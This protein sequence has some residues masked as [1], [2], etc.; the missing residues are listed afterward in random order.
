MA[1]TKSKKGWQTYV[2]LVC[3]ADAQEKLKNIEEQIKKLEQDQHELSEAIQLKKLNAEIGRVMNRWV[4]V[5]NYHWIDEK[6]EQ[7]EGYR[8]FKVV[9]VN[10]W[11]GRNAFKM[12]VRNVVYIGKHDVD[13][14]PNSDEYHVD[15]LHNWKVVSE[16]TV[17]KAIKNAREK[18][19]KKFDSI[20]VKCV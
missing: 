8:Y 17:E 14:I 12:C 20:L 10:K 7:V 11:E 19:N 9:G 18:I 16:E 5:P 1:L 2:K 6:N 3:E 4:K 15:D 13:F